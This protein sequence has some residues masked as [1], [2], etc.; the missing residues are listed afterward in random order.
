MN[1]AIH[2][3]QDLA[4]IALAAALG[5][6]VCRRAGLS[7]IVGYLF[8]GVLVGPH[9]PPQGLIT[10]LER[11][12]LFGQLGMLFLMFGI[13]LGFSFRRLRQLGLPVVAA[14]AGTAFLV[15]TAAR[16]GGM[17][18]GLDRVGT[19]FFAA[20]LTVS[21]SVVI[22]KML[23]DTGRTHEKS[24]QLALGI[25]LCEDLVAIVMLTMLGSY[26]QFGPEHAPMS[27]AE[28]LRTLGLF[29]GF[30]LVLATLGL[31]L[32]PRVLNRLG[33]GAGP[34]LI[35]LLVAGLLFGLA[36]M[37][38]Q[39]G[40][41]LA[42]G[43]FLL[44]AIMADTPQRATVERAFGG[45]K[46]LFG[47]VF[48]VAIGMTVDW[49]LLPDAF[50][51]LVVLTTLA[52]VGRTLA[53]GGMLVVLGYEAR[54]AWRSGLILTPIGEFSIII[55]QM[56]A[57][58]GLLPER[59]M[60]AAIGATLLTA[61][62]SPVLAA[63][64][65]AIAEWLASRR[66]P[67]VGTAAAL[68]RQLLDRLQRKKKHGALW[69]VLRRRLVQIL[70][71]VAFMSALLAL[72]QPAIEWTMDL[73]D[74]QSRPG[75]RTVLPYWMALGVLL[76]GPGIAVARNVNAVAMILADYAILQGAA[77]ER[78]RPLLTGSL[79]AGAA[80]LLLLWFWNFVPG[81][82]RG[83]AI[84]VVA[85]MLAALAAL[86]WR[87]LVHWQSAIEISLESSIGETAAEAVE[88]KSLEWM[89]RYAPLGLRINEI[90]ISDQSAQIG[91]SIGELG[92]RSRLGCT[93][94]GI[95]RQTV[96]IANPGPGVKLYPGDK[97]LVLGTAEHVAAARADLGA[98]RPNEAAAEH[99][100]RD[101]ALETITLPESGA[102]IGRSLA[103]LAWPQKF[104][105]QVVGCWRGEHCALNPAAEMQIARGD[106]LLVI[107]TPAQMRAL[108][109]A[110]A[111]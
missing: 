85:V 18:L 107:G 54:V 81:G 73:I 58:S 97:L 1:E 106:R 6:L 19:A 62:I 47:A 8:A 92:I 94:I 30:V 32:V 13:G 24:S 27:Q 49:R 4:V 55:A 69:K 39:A 89:D 74:P 86:L 66:L 14:T 40:Y 93:V 59:H 75:D 60:V 15:F 101:L 105:I 57:V 43:A 16:F 87:R 36:L 76:L 63:R 11:V 98:E 50:V 110:L 65:D 17:A 79:Q 95:D 31:L 23:A 82:A 70:V 83:W 71:A 52:L 91:R 84:L 22:G 44:G 34:E 20:L 21:S 5:G 96:M 35:T 37:V 42:L 77:Q 46:D 88:K 78:L 111:G 68:H 108:R 10:D 109:A 29:A 45:L 9:T 12:H 7:P 103:E 61:L 56:G 2:F 67:L 28:V 51:P 102:L 99:D 25:T 90:V 26:V 41:S 33:Q 100:F 104:G 72:A 3:I 64:N 53:A 38:V 80:V 48:F